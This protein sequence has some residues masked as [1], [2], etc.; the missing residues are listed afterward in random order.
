MGHEVKV[1]EAVINVR[2]CA[3]FIAEGRPR[4]SRVRAEETV[5][6]MERKDYVSRLLDT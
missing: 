4:I 5:N 3:L 2:E 1:D 6:E